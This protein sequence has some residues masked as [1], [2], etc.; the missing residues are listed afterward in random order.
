MR[1]LVTGATG[2]IGSHTVRA[3]LDAGH[4][5]RLFVRDEEKARR[6]WADRPEALDD[7][8][9]GKITSGP[10]TAI[11]L[12]DCDALVHTAAPVALGY[13]AAAA[14]RATR[15]NLRAIKLLVEAGLERGIERIVH[16]SSTTVLDCKGLEIADERAPVI[17]SGDAYARTKAAPERRVRE[18][19]DRGAPVSIVYPP[20]VVGPDDPGLS[21][22][23]AGLASQLQ[24]GVLVTSSGFQFVDVRDLAD[25]HRR[26]IERDPAPGRFITASRYLPWEEFAELLDECAGIRLPRFRVPGGTVR[27][28]GAAGDLLRR[29]VTVDPA[30]SREATRFATQW[31]EFD[32]SKTVDTLGAHFRDPRETLDDA[33]RWLAA[34]GH[35]PADRALRWTHTGSGR[36]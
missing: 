23:M 17:Q 11:A 1:V 9:V 2:F 31:V 16:L 12:R 21:E 29:F 22:S 25:V 10:A 5:V 28:L 35:V 36:D 20:G 13:G 15:E 18:L 6:V 14:R 4:R 32:A 30:I 33:V 19:Q 8:V 7:L 27:M 24:A 26:L 34:A 3:L